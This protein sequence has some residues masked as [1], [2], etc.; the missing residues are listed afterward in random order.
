M[1]LVNVEPVFCCAVSPADS[2][3]NLVVSGGE[4]DAAY[5]WNAASGEVDFK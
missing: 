2:S 4:D 1:F 3:N 5:V